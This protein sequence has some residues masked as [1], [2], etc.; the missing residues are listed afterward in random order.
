[1][2]YVVLLALAVTTTGCPFNDEDGDGTDYVAVDE[3]AAAYK[4]A[5]CAYLARCGLFPDQ[6]TCIAATLS[7]VPTLDPNVIAAVHAGRII[8]NGNNVK[9]CFDAVAN[10]T[11]DSTDENG[12][13]RTSACGAYFHGTIA[14]G[15][16]C[17]L[18]QECVSQVC[19]GGDTTNSCVRGRCVGDLAPMFVPI[20]LG[21][22]CSSSSQCGDGAYCD[23]VTNVCTTLKTNGSPCTGGPE[24]G[25]GLGCAG[26]TGAR[27]CQPLPG[28]GETCRLDLPCRD[29]GH[30]CDTATTPATCK[31]IG[32]AGATCTT[33]MHCSPYYRCD[34][35]AGSCVTLPTRG[36]SCSS[37]GRCFDADTYCASNTLTC[38]DTLADGMPCEADLECQSATCD[39]NLAV[40]VCASP[41]LCI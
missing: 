41:M 33:S 18:D 11:C 16:D 23:T 29:D 31:Q 22:S 4:E 39:F 6:A 17:M 38:D 34:N 1:M 9:A 36:Q 19:S 10:D 32:V 5:Y 15:G 2:R 14:D 8:Y 13:T 35:T 30:Y 24:C 25:Y 37:V 28:L 27:T 3:M 21:E 20:G 40:P 7:V 12:R 26:S